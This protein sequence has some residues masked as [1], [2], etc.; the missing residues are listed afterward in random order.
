MTLRPALLASALS[1][2]TP[3]R[4]DAALG[5]VWNY[6]SQYQFGI[7]YSNS[8]DYV[9]LSYSTAVSGGIPSSCQAL[10]DD[11]TKK[12]CTVG[13]VGGSSSG[14]GVFL[15][16]AFKKQGQ[17]YLDWDVSAGARY[18]SGQIPDND[19]SKDGLPLR[20]AS[21]SLAAFVVKPYIQ[22]GVTPEFWPDI[23]VSM[24][25]ALQVAVGNVTVNDSP[26]NIVVGTSSL[27]GP[28]SLLNGFFA[29]E[30]VLKRFGEGAF[31]FI[32][33]HDFS[34]NGEGSKI[35]PDEIDGMSD[36]RGS[37][38]RDVG[39]LA[40]GFGLKLVTPWP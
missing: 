11:P 30:I 31:S 23:L 1:L 32:A 29:L 27:T 35:H 26:R 22:F 12:R 24:G 5:E 13:M 39:G 18:L 10:T 15:E 4:A 21:F 19:I 37:F 17:Y 9:A 16:K 38:K 28:M 14:W 3:G 7:D 36:F 34:G 40:Y 2:A 8:M 25:P 6:V 33:S 20:Y